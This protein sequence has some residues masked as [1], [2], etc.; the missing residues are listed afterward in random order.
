MDVIDA[1][2]NRKSV[3]AFTDQEVPKDLVEEVLTIA[4]RSPSGTNTQPWHTYVCTG[5]VR[6]TIV[7]DTLALVESGA[8]DSY[9]ALNY[10]PDRWKDIHRDRR[11]GIGWALYGA[12]GIQKGDREASAR[13]GARNFEFFDAPVGI[14]VTIDGYLLDGSFADA[15]MYI[16]TIM[17]A[18]RG[19]GLETCPQAAWI[20]FQ[21][22][23]RKHLGI[24]EDEKLVSGMSM[25]YANWDAVENGIVSE[26][27]AFENVVNWR[28]F[29]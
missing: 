27:E 23:L 13:Q 6:D 19:K 22:P 17:L 9:E 11:R 15:G 20:P 4:Q 7:K 21:G 29:D 18:A 8:A 3:R 26:R 12:L 16:Q 14:F 2:V 5:A 1:I 10:Y 28:G 25:G 24:P